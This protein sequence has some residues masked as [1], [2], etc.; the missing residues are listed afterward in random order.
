MVSQRNPSSDGCE[1]PGGTAG[2]RGAVRQRQTGVM[3]EVFAQEAI[4]ALGPDQDS[5]AL[6]AAITAAI[7]GH[8]QHEPPCPLA[9]H[10]SQADRRG[11]DVVVRTLFAVEPEREQE[12]RNRI[13]AAMSAGSLLGPDGVTTVWTL[14]R[15]QPSYVRAGEI[16]HAQRLKD[17]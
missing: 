11:Q 9:P 5:R 1:G 13:T 7:C 2:R 10:H 16:Q 17:S 3:R 8:W 4:V 15:C 14:R 12:I 6:G